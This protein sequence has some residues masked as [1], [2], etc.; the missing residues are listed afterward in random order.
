MFIKM[1]GSI[2][3]VRKGYYQTWL[4]VWSKCRTQSKAAFPI[5]PQNPSKPSIYSFNH[6][7]SQ[8]IV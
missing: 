4:D 1:E 3:N 7:S 8:L 2:I 6:K 5:H